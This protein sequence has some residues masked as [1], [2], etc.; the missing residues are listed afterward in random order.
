M[1]LYIS[2]YIR[3]CAYR[4]THNIFLYHFCNL[5]FQPN[6]YAFFKARNVRLRNSE[7]I[8]N[9]FLRLCRRTA[10]AET[11]FHYAFFARRKLVERNEQKLFVHLV[12]NVLAHH[13]R[14]GA[15]NIGQ[16]QFVAVPVN[17][18]RFVD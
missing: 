10:H 12:F 1:F 8:C 17:V 14:V 9:L 4:A 5:F 15:E 7:H 6:D 3:F 2:N 16:K 13:V 11:E 18:K